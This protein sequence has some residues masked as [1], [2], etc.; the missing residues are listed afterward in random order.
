MN[1]F[2]CPD[3]CNPN[4]NGVVMICPSDKYKRQKGMNFSEEAEFRGICKLGTETLIAC[5]GESAN[6]MFFSANDFR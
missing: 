6:E 5:Y 4:Y 3:N 2:I 1:R